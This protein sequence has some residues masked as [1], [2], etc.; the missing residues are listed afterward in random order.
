[1]RRAVALLAGVCVTH[2][3]DPLDLAFFP[4]PHRWLC[5]LHYSENVGA[6]FW[7]LRHL[8]VLFLDLLPCSSCFFLTEVS[9]LLDSQ[10]ACSHV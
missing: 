5:F 2:V 6:P 8:C 9:C 7:S 10:A 1:M 3:G 4:L